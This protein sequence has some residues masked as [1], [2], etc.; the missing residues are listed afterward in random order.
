M[1]ILHPEHD[2]LAVRGRR[3]PAIKIGRP[4]VGIVRAGQLGPVVAPDV[5]R[6]FH[7][8]VPFDADGV[9]EELADEVA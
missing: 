5:K 7:H 9:Q 8:V 1:R 2:L 3:Q 6:V 4:G